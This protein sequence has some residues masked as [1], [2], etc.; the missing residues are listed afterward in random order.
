M[1]IHLVSYLLLSLL[2]TACGSPEPGVLRLA[3][4]TST[5]NSGLLDA[6]LPDFEEANHA[7]VDVIAVGTGQA[8]AL[9]EAGDADI[10]LVHAR[11]RE[12]A[13]I[14][15]GHGLER[16]DVMY[17]DFIIVGPSGSGKSTLVDGACQFSIY[18]HFG[19]CHHQY[20]CAEFLG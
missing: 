18:F 19:I 16:F 8:L 20:R 14:E 10:I 12:D 4:T 2:L 11:S 13:F 1:R 3:T 7:R 6:I 17:N 15:A 9:G 5:D